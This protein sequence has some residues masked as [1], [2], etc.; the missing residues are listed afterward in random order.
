MSIRLRQSVA[1]SK[2]SS[3]PNISLTNQEMSKTIK[4]IVIKRV[5]SEDIG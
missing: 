4:K 3:N 1:A 2:P 5:L